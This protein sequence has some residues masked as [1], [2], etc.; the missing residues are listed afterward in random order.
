LIKVK[1]NQPTLY[2]QLEQH[3]QQP[4]SHSYYSHERTR[5]RHSYRRVQVF[6]PPL[7]LDPKWSAVGCVI[8]VERTGT[9][10]GLPYQHIGYYLSSLAPSTRRL[11]IG[12]RQHWQIENRLHWVKDVVYQED[13]SPKLAGLAA[14]NLSLLKTW[15]LSLFRIHGYDSLTEAI[16]F[17]SHNIKYLLSLCY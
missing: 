17:S 6:T 14:I 12:L 1:A 5:N 15:V 9:R 13:S 16:S 3:T 4:P 10:A 11:A 7:D 8:R 2:Q